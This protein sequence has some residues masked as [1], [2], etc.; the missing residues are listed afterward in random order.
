MSDDKRWVCEQKGSGA[1]AG[2]SVAGARKV[3]DFT[4]LTL[5]LGGRAEAAHGAR[6]AA[7]LLRVAARGVHQLGRDQVGRGDHVPDV[8]VD[9][10][11]VRVRVRFR[12]RV[13]RL[14][15]GSALGFRG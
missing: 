8:E 7:R 15:L 13:R 2:E 1:R 12:V 10:V 5:F 4:W 11:R 9:L 6:P 3:R 14:G